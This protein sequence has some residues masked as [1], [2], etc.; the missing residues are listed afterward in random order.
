T[1]ALAAPRDWHTRRAEE[2]SKQLAVASSTTR[3]PLLLSLLRS[4]ESDAVFWKVVCEKWC[5]CDC[6][7]DYRHVARSIMAKHSGPG[8]LDI[9]HDM[10]PPGD[11]P[12]VIRVWR[13]CTR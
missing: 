4:E 10:R 8:W 1:N 9:P 13:G 3:L 2:I 6:T 7:W 5:S 11:W 12:S